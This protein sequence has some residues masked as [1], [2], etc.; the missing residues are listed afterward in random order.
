MLLGHDPEELTAT[1]QLMVL[2]KKG[3]P[4]PIVGPDTDK[5]SQVDKRQGDSPPKYSSA[6][7]KMFHG[8][9]TVPTGVSMAEVS[10]L[11]VIA[12]VRLVTK[13]YYEEHEK[14]LSTSL[15]KGETIRQAAIQN[16]SNPD[17]E[18]FKKEYLQR[19]NDNADLIQTSVVLEAQADST[20]TCSDAN[21]KGAR[22]A[23]EQFVQEQRG[24]NKHVSVMVTVPECPPLPNPRNQIATEKNAVAKEGSC[25]TGKGADSDDNLIDGSV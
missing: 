23:A 14:H 20:S 13:A 3:K 9:T 21:L 2:K 1:L 15:S 25:A 5:D 19:L 24:K 11:K 12:N 4:Q 16:L 8:A 7:R 6:R 22:E 17:S 18:Y 10:P